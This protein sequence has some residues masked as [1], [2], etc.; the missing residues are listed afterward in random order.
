M[1][2]DSDMGDRQLHTVLVELRVEIAANYLAVIIDTR[3][4]CAPGIREVQRRVRLCGDVKQEPMLLARCIVIIPDNL[5]GVVQP[6]GKSLR[7]AR[8]ARNCTP[9]W[10]FRYNPSVMPVPETMPNPTI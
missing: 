10:P 6:E 1:R 3:C 5:P 4:S 8:G 9:P 7:R 2:D